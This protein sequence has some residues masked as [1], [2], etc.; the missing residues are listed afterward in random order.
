MQAIWL[1]EQ[2]LRFREDVPVPTPGK[3]EALIKILLAGL[4]STDLELV[5]GYYPFSG[6]P[7]HEFVGRVVSSPSDPS[8]IEKRVV[9]EINIACGKCDTC[10]SGLNRHCERRKTLG[11]HDWNGVFAEY[12]VLPLANLHVVPTHIPDDAAVFTEPLA[13]AHEILDQ[14]SLSTS[15]RVLLI[16]AGR[17]G[18]LIASVFH[19]AGSQL[20]VLARHTRQ[21]ELLVRGNINVI[22]KE[23]INNKSYH[24]VVEATG[25]AD[26]FEVAMKSIRPRGRIILKS[27]YKGNVEVNFSRIVVDEITLIGS[28]CGSFEPAL[29]LL[30][31][32]EIDP[33][34]LIDATY[35]LD[36]GLPA[37]EHASKSGVLKVLIQPGVA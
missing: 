13:A 32:G 23:D 9:G 21:R 28:R 12:M 3:G 4:C 6:I 26:G 33:R 8:W 11:I 31:R 5:R 29:G 22:D 15:D 30:S 34:Q 7:G 37:F 35:S 24:V 27:T 19:G 2:T 25:T 20:D 14:I 10:K 17:L 18:Q 36:Q 16:G 1:E